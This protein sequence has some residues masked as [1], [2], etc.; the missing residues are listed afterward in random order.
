MNRLPRNKMEYTSG[1]V[2]PA[3]VRDGNRFETLGDIKIY[4]RNYLSNYYTR[5]FRAYKQPEKAHNEQLKGFGLNRDELVP[6][7]YNEFR[8]P[9]IYDE[10]MEGEGLKE[11]VKKIK[12]GFKKPTKKQVKQFVENNK[13]D[14]IKLA[15][16]KG[17]PAATAATTAALLT[18]SGNPEFAPVIAPIVGV[19]VK[20]LVKMK[21]GYGRQSDLTK[22]RLENL[23][24]A[25]EAKKN[26][27][28]EKE[29]G[30]TGD[31]SQ[32]QPQTVSIDELNPSKKTCQLVKTS[33]KYNCGKVEKDGKSTS[34]SMTTVIK[35][36]DQKTGQGRP[37]RK[38]SP[39]MEARNKLVKKLMKENG[40]T[41]MAASKHIKQENL[42]Y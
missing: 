27:G 15:I 17:V 11:V 37:K 13:Q 21:T 29:V 4:R 10:E 25:R 34:K 20:N 19:F 8:V 40:M 3:D 14:I 16:N 18:V 39:K 23:E 2:G 5:D 9:K 32:S 28:K 26:K 38:I 24:K 36:V 6:K 35:D 41:L 31:A 7:K 30:E 12:K 33:K 42:K 1:S 22:K